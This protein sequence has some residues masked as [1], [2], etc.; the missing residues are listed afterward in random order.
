MI[1]GRLPQ[2]L[3]GRR[4]MKADRQ[5]QVRQSLPQRYIVRI[6]P[7]P[8]RRVGRQQDRAQAKLGGA[9]SLRHGPLDR[10]SQRQRRD[11]QQAARRHRAVLGEPVVVDP[12]TFAAVLQIGRPEHVHRVVRINDL[13]AQVVEVLIGQPGARIGCARARFGG[14]VMRAAHDRRSG[15]LLVGHRRDGVDEIHRN[16]AVDNKEVAA[17]GIRRHWHVRKFLGCRK[18]GPRHHARR[19]IAKAAIHPLLPQVDGLGHV[20]V[21][22]DEFV[23]D[24]RLAHLRTPCT[25]ALESIR[26]RIIALL[27]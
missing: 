19:P 4:V 1:Q 10:A 14:A 13:G 2:E 15:R 12:E 3:L 25:R 16:Q 9:L 21:S 22:G 8:I 20:P 27:D 23:I 6:S 5:L 18:L 26:T 17:F 11:P 24:C 7:R